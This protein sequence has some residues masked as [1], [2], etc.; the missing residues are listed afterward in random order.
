MTILSTTPPKRIPRW[1]IVAA[2]IVGWVMLGSGGKETQTQSP[3]PSA[4]RLRPLNPLIPNQQAVTMRDDTYGCRD[5]KDLERLSG[6]CKQFKSGERVMIRDDLWST[7][8]VSNL[9]RL[10]V[11]YWVRDETMCGSR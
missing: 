9:D 8:S 6:D 3:S 4:Q 1:L 11:C 2:C 10:D 7:Q 5:R